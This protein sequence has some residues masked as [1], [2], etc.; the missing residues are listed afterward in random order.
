MNLLIRRAPAN[1]H[2]VIACHEIPDTLDV[3]AA[4]L[5]KHGAILTADELRFTG[6]EIA[7]FFGNGRT[8]RNLESL[9]SATNGWPI[10]LRIL[11]NQRDCPAPAEANAAMYLAHNW[12]ESRL[13]RSV[14]PGDCELLLDAGLFDWFDTD[15]IDEVLEG[16][17]CKRRLES[18]PILNGLVETVRGRSPETIRLH[19]LIRE[20]CGTRRLRETPERFRLVHRRIAD[21]LRRRGEIVAAMRHAAAADDMR[22]AADILEGVGP[23]QLWARNGLAP[24]QAASRLLSEALVESRPRLAIARCMVALLTGKLGEARRIFR[25]QVGDHSGVQIGQDTSSRLRLERTIVRGMLA[26]HGCERVDSVTA[27]AVEAEAERMLEI[28]GLE[29]WIQGWFEHGLCIIRHLKAEFGSARYHAQRAQRCLPAEDFG[30]IY[31]K[32]QLGQ[33]AMAQGD[34]SEATEQYSRARDRIRGSF[35]RE[36]GPKAFVDSFISELNLERNRTAGIAEIPLIQDALGASSTPVAACVACA[37]VA[38]DLTRQRK[39]NGEALSVAEEMLEFARTVGLPLVI[40]YLAIERVSML[41]VSG[42]VGQAERM[43]GEEGLPEGIVECLDLDGQ[44]WREMEALSCARLRLLTARGEFASSREMLNGLLTITGERNLVRTRMRALALGIAL[45]RTADRPAN[46][47]RYLEQ[48]LDLYDQADYA[49]PIARDS[50]HCLP[51]LAD[52]LSGN[53]DTQERAAAYRLAIV[54]Q[55][56]ERWESNPQTFSPRELEVLRRLE[57]LTDNAIAAALELTKG[58][59]RYH[60][61]NLFRKLQA[62]DRESAVKRARQLGLLL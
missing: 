59:V 23:V 21:A 35:L 14:S 22:L 51:A 31:V 54:L 34:L 58:G 52:Y 25:D 49:R 60:V 1:F 56:N 20:H 55:D 29:P 19:P 46:A 2:L 40:R 61:A 48:F 27:K 24:L 8:R 50:T 44:T 7:R 13:F 36:P 10:A 26:L 45:E 16:R 18:I 5:D 39:G 62:R 15:L 47:E 38:L 17:G 37:G 43:W 30:Q 41:V 32:L 28:D 12:M 4:I 42:N 3:A 33:I 9:V 53:P 6:H 11:Q 57:S